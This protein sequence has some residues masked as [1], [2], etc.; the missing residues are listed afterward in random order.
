MV[1][2]HST[3]AAQMI[4]LAK[5][6]DA[7]GSLHTQTMAPR[8]ESVF[9]RARTVPYKGRQSKYKRTQTHTHRKGYN[10]LPGITHPTHS[11]KPPHY[12]GQRAH[13]SGAALTPNCCCCC[14]CSWCVRKVL[15]CGHTKTW[16]GDERQRR[17]GTFT[18]FDSV[19]SV[20]VW[21]ADSGCVQRFSASHT[22]GTDATKRGGVGT[23]LV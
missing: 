23:G 20:L 5:G 14:C 8:S 11:L 12:H 3:Q 2:G 19:R 18:A 15:T 22:N 13:G 21:V 1:C 17:D 10:L 4:S 9:H 7:D 16:Q 6:R